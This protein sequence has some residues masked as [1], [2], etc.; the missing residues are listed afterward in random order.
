[1]TLVSRVYSPAI[2]STSNQTHQTIFN[3]AE[4]IALNVRCSIILLSQ[5]MN[6]FLVF[7]LE[8]LNKG[9]QLWH[10]HNM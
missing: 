8:L 7:L 4:E 1:M 6:S 9:Q 3:Q 5:N 2:S 10:K